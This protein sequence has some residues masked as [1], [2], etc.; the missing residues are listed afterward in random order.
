MAGGLYADMGER[1]SGR[2]VGAAR[3]VGSWKE[4]VMAD[5]AP[6]VPDPEL[7]PKPSEKMAEEGEREGPVEADH[8]QPA[9]VETER[10]PQFARNG[11]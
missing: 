6:P 1:A 5:V 2:N 8:T 7:K 11:E 9:Q 10:D 3:R 4:S